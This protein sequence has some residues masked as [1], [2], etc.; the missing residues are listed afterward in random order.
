MTYQEAKKAA[1]KK[2][3]NIFYMVEQPDGT[4]SE[5]YYCPLR[6]RQIWTWVNKEGM[7]AK[8][9]SERIAAYRKRQKKLGRKKREYYLTDPEAKVVTE[10]V[11]DMR[12]ESK[13]G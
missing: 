2:N 9:P 13:D 5:V 3:A 7:R 11:A 12:K 6:G 10:V 1:T 8:P 4:Q